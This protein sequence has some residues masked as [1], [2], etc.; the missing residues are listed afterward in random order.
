MPPGGS[1]RKT[2][3]RSVDDTA[4]AI[5]DNSYRHCLLLPKS[6]CGTWDIDTNSSLVRK[7]RSAIIGVELCASGFPS[8]RTHTHPYFP[9]CLRRRVHWPRHAASWGLSGCL[10]RT[11]SRPICSASRPMCTCAYRR[12]DGFRRFDFPRPCPLGDGNQIRENSKRG[13]C[14][15]TAPPAGPALTFGATATFTDSK[16][17]LTP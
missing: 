12:S 7:V 5:C 11:A 13:F 15:W 3:D 14:Q 10:S 1:L 16:L 8:A 4:R 9:L 17:T 6:L 2:I